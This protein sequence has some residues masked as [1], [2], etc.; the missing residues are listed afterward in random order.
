MDCGSGVDLCGVLTLCSGLGSGAYE[1]P[2]PSVHG[3]WP[4]AAVEHG[5][6]EVFGTD[7]TNSQLLL[8]ACASSDKK[9]KLA[10]VA[11][12]PTACGDWAFNSAKT[13]IA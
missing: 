3:L 10:A 9:W 12:F 5:G 11:D 2:A 6:Y 13:A 4:E 8:S 7:A 1:H